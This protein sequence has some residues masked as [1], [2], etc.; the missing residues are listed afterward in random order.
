[1][2]KSR[3]AKGTVDKIVDKVVH[4]VSDGGPSDRIPGGP[5]REPAALEEPTDPAGAARRPSPTRAAR[6]R[7]PPTGT[8]TGAPADRTGP[9]RG[10]LTT[11]QGLRLTGH[12]PLAEGRP[13]RADAAA[14]P[15]PAREDHATSTTSA[16]PS[17]SCTPA[18]PAP[19]ASFAAYGNGRDGHQGRLPRRGRRDAGLRPVLDR[20][21][22]RA[23]RPTRCATPAASRRSS[24]PTRATSTWSATTSR[25][26]SSRTASSSPTSSTPASRTRTGRSRRRRARTTRSGTS[27]RCTPRPA[28]TRCGTCPTAASRAP[29]G[30]WR[31]SASTPSGW[32]TPKAATTLVK[33][34]WKPGWACTRWS[35]RRRRLIAGMDP[36]F[37]RRDLAD[38]IEAGAYPEWELGIQ[39]FP[40]TPDQTFEGIDLLDPTKIVPEEL[41]PVQ[42]IGLLTLNANPVELLRRDRAGRL[43]PGHTWCPA[44]T[45]PTTRCCRRGCSPT[46]TPRSPGSAAPTSRQI[47]I[48]RPHAPVNDMLRD[49]LHQTAVHGGVAPY[50]PNSLDG[51]CPVHRRRRRGRLHRR[52][53]AGARGGE[54]ARGAGV[55]RRPLQPGPPVLAEPDPGGAR[56]RHR[57]L[58]LR[59]RQVLRAGDQGAAAAGAR[60]H[61]RRP[62]RSRWPQGLGLP[63]PGADGRAAADVEPSPALSQLGRH[64]AHR[65]AGSSASSPTTTSDLADV[66]RPAG[67]IL[68]GGHGAAGDRPAG[69]HSSRRG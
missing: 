27:S 60:Q 31:A 13:A 20:A 7:S 40:D 15:P 37:H 30:R 12:R 23:G 5:G 64:L 55:V 4:A 11:A 58:H 52:A 67:A 50:R 3:P 22:A 21:R 59:A 29:T 1:M 18:A 42:P 44:S 34:H 66:T 65:P 26:S 9:G 33:F 8:P 45:S 47:P 10:Y 28:T 48:N 53:R 49:G 51:G 63:G 16:S 69:R 38:A 62:V 32:S 61:R 14:G 35:G 68:D 17:G 2:E 6:R 41:A 54:G 39:V 57:R 56:A 19:T 43:P 36:D 46:W 24:T 25:C